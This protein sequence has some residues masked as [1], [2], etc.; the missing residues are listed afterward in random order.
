M[1]GQV[2][3]DFDQSVARQLFQG[4]RR[5]YIFEYKFVFAV[6]CIFTRA[7]RTPNQHKV[8]NI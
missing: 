1:R 2:S 5:D 8:L 4:G 6:M 7:F 3:F